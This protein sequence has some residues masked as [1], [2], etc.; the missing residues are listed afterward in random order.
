MKKI[1]KGKFIIIDGIDGSGKKTQTKAIVKKIKKSGL[2]VETIDFPRYYN[3]FFGKLI[4]R[5]LSGEFGTSA[6]ISPYLASVL[7]AADRFESSKK[8]RE[9][10]SKGCIV[11]ADRYAS[12]NQIH[13]GGK[14]KDAKKRKKFLEWLNEMEFEVFK[15]PKP[16]MIVYLNV[17]CKI[18]EKLLDN[19]DSKNRK[20]YLGNKKDIHESDSDHLENARKSAL[21]LVKEQ[22]NW[23]NIECVENNKLLPIKDITDKIWKNIKNYIK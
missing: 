6:E 12:S 20:K 10:L 18:S 22:N 14:I 2:N 3:N 15:I 5:Y 11:I 9:W 19:T 21:K 13:Q 17:S 1:K 8:I 7:Y 16:D 4:G 23:I